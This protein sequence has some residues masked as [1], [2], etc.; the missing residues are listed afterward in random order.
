M[1]ARI[2][3]FWCGLQF[4]PVLCCTVFPGVTCHPQVIHLVCP[5]GIWVVSTLGLY[6]DPVLL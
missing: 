2:T 3:H 5:D 4:L 6:K 1:L